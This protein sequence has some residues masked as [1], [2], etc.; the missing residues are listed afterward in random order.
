MKICELPSHIGVLYLKTLPNVKMKSHGHLFSSF[1]D[2]QLLIHH[3]F[4][5]NIAVVMVYSLH[6]K[7]I[8][9][10]EMIEE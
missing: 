8:H 3:S 4:A 2:S 1:Y 5:Y 6:V 9:F 10:I 7:I